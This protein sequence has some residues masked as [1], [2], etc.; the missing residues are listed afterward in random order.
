MRVPGLAVQC[1][2]VLLLRV[3]LHHSRVTPLAQE[4]AAGEI[5]DLLANVRGSHVRRPRRL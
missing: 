3:G 4:V 1:P 2:N 5:P